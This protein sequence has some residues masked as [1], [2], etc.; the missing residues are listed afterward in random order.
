MKLFIFLIF[1]I[2]SLP[3]SWAQEDDRIILAIETL[4]LPASFG[5]LEKNQADKIVLKSV[6]KVK[7]YQLMIGT[8]DQTLKVKHSIHYVSVIVIESPKDVFSINARLFDERVKK[9]IKKI[10]VEKVEKNSFFRELEKAMNELFFPTEPPGKPLEVKETKRP[11]KKPKNLTAPDENDAANIAFKQRIM[12]LKIDIDKKIVKIIEEKEQAEQE[13][14]TKKKNLPSPPPKAAVVSETPF[15]EEPEP[16]TEFPPVNP[17]QKLGLFYQRLTTNYAGAP[18]DDDFDSGVNDKQLEVNTSLTYTGLSYLYQRPIKSNTDHYIQ[19]EV[20][21]AK[22][23]R[24]TENEVSPY[25]RLASNYGYFLRDWNFF[26]HTGLEIDTQS[27]IVLTRV[28]EGLST[29]NNQILNLR[30]GGKVSTR[31]FNQLLSFSL[32]YSL[33]IYLR[34]DNEIMKEAKVTGNKLNFSFLA[35]GLYKRINLQADYF[36]SKYTYSNSLTDLTTD[37]SG[38]SINV[39]YLF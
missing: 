27:F 4:K 21:L 6:T 29:A 33:P 28:G 26:P 15:T 1:L 13:A 36:L 2:S 39:N 14:K 24:K 35:I 8:L 7:D 32:L 34:S 10:V 38:W 17:I 23:M 25:I 3:F 31:Y 22:S 18:F 12:N 11:P 5:E 19:G 9:L 37:S 16:V 20:D 30:F